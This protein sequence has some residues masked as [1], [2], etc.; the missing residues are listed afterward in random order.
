MDSHSRSPQSPTRRV[1]QPVTN[2]LVLGYS[3]AHLWVVIQR[4]GMPNSRSDFLGVFPA[5]LT[6]LCSSKTE[7]VLEVRIG[8]L[9]HTG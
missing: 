7:Q 6:S 3:F 2:G 4:H 9:A 1:A 5:F 8:A